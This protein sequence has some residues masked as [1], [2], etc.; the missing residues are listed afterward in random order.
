[1]GAPGRCSAISW[2]PGEKTERLYE[3]LRT[4]FDMVF[5][6]GTSS[7]FPYIQ[8]PVI[9]ANRMGT[10]TIEINPDETVISGQVDYRLDLGAAA[11]MDAIW[12]RLR[13]GK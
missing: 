11:A 5:S 9:A 4:G 7:V 12:T 8:E 3:E 1:M 13:Q 2:L 10:P 6:I